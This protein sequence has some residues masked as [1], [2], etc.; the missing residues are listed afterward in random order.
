MNLATVPELEALLSASFHAMVE[1]SGIVIGDAE[2]DRVVLIVLPDLDGARGVEA[3]GEVGLA[4]HEANEDFLHIKNLE[5]KEFEGKCNR[6]GKYN[7][8]L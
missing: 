1:H 7:I 2:A 5:K 6:V 4:I 8:L 3:V